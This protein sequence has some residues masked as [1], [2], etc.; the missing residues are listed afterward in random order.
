MVVFLLVFLSLIVLLFPWFS[1]WSLVIVVIIVTNPISFGHG[2][3]LSWLQSLL[4]KSLGF[5]C[6]SFFIEIAIIAEIII[7]SASLKLPS[8]LQSSFLAGSSDR[9]RMSHDF[10]L[11]K[12]LIWLWFLLQA[13]EEFYLS[14]MAA[15][16]DSPTRRYRLVEQ[17]GMTLPRSHFP[18]WN[19][20][21]KTIFFL[22]VL[23]LCMI[24]FYKFLP[25]WLNSVGG[26]SG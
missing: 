25:Q 19:L 5:H 18:R 26:Q 23:I 6:R 15:H 1:S 22:I 3:E 21:R 14:P 13:L 4:V 20:H 9:L 17:Q 12:D 16:P 2:P 7:C 8:R 11:S 10:S 24:R